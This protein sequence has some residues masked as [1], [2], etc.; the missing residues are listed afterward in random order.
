ML[1][2]ADNGN[3]R[4]LGGGGDGQGGGPGLPRPKF[5]P[6]LTIPVLLLLL[7]VFSSVISNAGT[8]Q[9]EYSR[10]TQ[11][12]TDGKITGTVTISNSDISG[13]Y[14]DNGTD[15]AFTTQLA[16]NLQLDSTFTDFL[17]T[18]GVQFKFT[19]PSVLTACSSTSCRSCW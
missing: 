18:N 16:P 5:S 1:V 11:L 8:T 12:V 15:V 3:K 6:W 14:D 9:L 2:M 19:Q 13:T 7:I 10:F 17:Q 4:G